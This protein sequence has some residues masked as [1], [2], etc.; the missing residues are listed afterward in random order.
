[1]K[2][3]IAEKTIRRNSDDDKNDEGK[4]KVMRA[5]RHI[6]RRESHENKYRVLKTI[7]ILK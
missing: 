3:N 1:M 6:R 5:S 2:P 4:E 7:M